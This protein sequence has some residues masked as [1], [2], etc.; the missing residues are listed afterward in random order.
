M[1]LIDNLN[2][3]NKFALMLVFPIVGLLYFSVV[4][5]FVQYN[6]L[7][8]MSK[9]QHLADYSVKASNLVHELQKERGMTAGYLG[10]KGKKFV[11]KLPEQRRTVDKQVAELKAYLGK[12][13][14]NEYGGEELRNEVDIIIGDLSALTAKREAITNLNIL[15]KMAI[16]YITG[17]N[18]KFLLSIGEVATLSSNAEITNLSSAYV[19]FLQGK[20]RAG[21]ERA[22]LTGTFGANKFAKGAYEK[23]LSLVVLQNTYVD[24]FKS[25]ANKEQKAFFSETLKGAD[26]NEVNRL[27][28]VAGDAELRTKGFGIDGAHWFQVSSG[29][30]NLLKKIE[31]YLADNVISR[32]N[33]LHAAAKSGFFS[34]LI[35]S[36]VITLVTLIFTFLV[37]RG[38]TGPLGEALLRMKDIAE[39]EGDLT[40]RIDIKSTDEIGQLCAA[41]NA[42]IEKIHGVISNVKSSATGLSDAANQVST[43]SQDLSSGSS[44]QAASVEETSSS[45]EEMSAT[46]NQNADNAKQTETMA[47]TASSQA[48]EGGDQVSQTVTAMTDIAEKIA[49][50]EDIAY[51]TNLLALNAAIEAARAGEHGKGFAVVASEVRKLA[52]RS[53]SAA[54][55]ISSLAKSSVSIAVGAGKLLEEIVPS[56]KKTADLVQEISA[57]SEEQASGIT[58]VNGAMGQLDTVTQSNAALAEEL[59]ATAEEMSAQTQ[60]LSD[61]MSFFTVLDDAGV[62]TQAVNQRVTATARPV[63]QVKTVSEPASNL[64]DGNIPEGFQRY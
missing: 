19:N 27:R 32:T 33:E 13:N 53:E 3:R 2:I 51:Q 56:I 17:I 38:V 52:G 15:P 59:S 8:E 41:A 63:S 7:S 5:I 55:E 20:E 60:A 37:I 64:D 12:Y 21:I 48:E 1:K 10:S 16:G 28:R 34:S 23:F 49:I 6:V 25:F 18:T 58:E 26:V 31:N 14:I 57:S 43:A 30:I 54:G 39:G 11:N 36:A 29:R 45:L 47:T 35:I 50:I 4:E 24:V 40:K 44:E 9:I 46:V 61:M 22:V 42:F 62:P